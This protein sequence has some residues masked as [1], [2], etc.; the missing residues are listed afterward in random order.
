MSRIINAFIFTVLL[1]ACAAQPP[2]QKKELIQCP[3]QRPQICAREY[4]PV[5]ATRDTGVRCVTTPCPA[6]EQ[7]TYSNGCS[8]CADKNVSGYAANACAQIPILNSPQ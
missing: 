7:K 1:V 8:A 3:E 5:C 4:M 6:S 2:A